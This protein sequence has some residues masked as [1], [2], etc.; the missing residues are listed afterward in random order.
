MEMHIDGE[1][2]RAV[3]RRVPSPVVVVTASA[4]EVRG[5]TIGSF[6]SVSLTPPLISFN[7]AL[8]S[9]MYPVIASTERF[10]VHIL[11]DEQVLLARKFGLPDIPGAEQFQNVS[12]RE[13]E[14]GLPVLLDALGVLFCRRFAIYPA[15]DHSIIVGEVEAVEDRGAG[16]PILYYNRTYRSVGDVVMPAFPV[17][18]NRSSSESPATP[19]PKN[20]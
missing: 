15:G 13:E 14:D 5:A 10:A 8:D 6:T 20:A 9:Q 11:G 19:D 7:V 16:T 12:F 3:M 17:T 2:L 18:T 4:N 1:V